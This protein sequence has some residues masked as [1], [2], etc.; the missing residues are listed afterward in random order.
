[1]VDMF[2]SIGKPSE[3]FEVEAIYLKAYWLD[4]SSWL[5][6]TMSRTFGVQKFFA[7]KLVAKTN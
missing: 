3:F 7:E 2:T 6:T 1:M 4:R 5:K